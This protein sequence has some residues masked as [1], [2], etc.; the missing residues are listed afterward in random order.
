MDP[1]GDIDIAPRL[2]KIV[3]APEE[4]SD[5]RRLLL[6]ASAPTELDWSDFDHVAEDRDYLAS[7][8][9]GALQQSAKGVNI[10]LYGPNGTGK[11]ELSK[12]LANPAWRDPVRGRGK[13]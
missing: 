3:W 2:E 5:V 1:D 6:G 12:V 11:T 7:I 8:L 9:A 10:L 4:K 13:G